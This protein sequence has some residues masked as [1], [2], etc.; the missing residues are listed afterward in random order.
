M[1]ACFYFL[2]DRIKVTKPKMY[3]LA[4]SSKL[5]DGVLGV[6]VIGGRIRFYAFTFSGC[7]L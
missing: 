5:L 1:K 7:E 3:N 4:Q 6:K 2:P